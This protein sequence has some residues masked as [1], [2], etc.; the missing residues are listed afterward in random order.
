MDPWLD[1]FNATRE[2]RLKEN[3]SFALLGEQLTVKISVAPEVGFRLSDLRRKVRDD[4][5]ASKLAAERGE[6]AP[7]DVTTDAEMLAVAEDT[8]V[9]CLDP[10]SLPA[11]RRLR[12]PGR[13]VPLSFREI[14]AL[15]DYILARASGIPT[16][17]PSDSSAGPQNTDS[18]STDDSPSP[19]PI[20]AV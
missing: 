14:F 10:E 4:L 18:S 7:A 8:I 5:E 6:P 2:A 16:E 1:N 3:R 20:R 19:A 15:C 9:A 17:G 13:V 12:E 11:W